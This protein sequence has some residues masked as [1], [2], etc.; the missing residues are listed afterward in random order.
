MQKNYLIGIGGTGA[1]V[2]ES[3][4][5]MCAAGYGPD[6]LSLFMVDP[7]A[8]NGNLA[9][10]SQL[11]KQY[12]KCRQK[13]QRSKNN[14]LF[15]TDLKAPEKIVWDIFDKKKTRLSD[16]INYQNIQIKKRELA[17]FVSVLFSDEELDTPLDEGFRG[18]PAIGAVVMANPPEDEYPF[19]I[20]WDDIVNQP[21]NGVRVFIVGSVF[22]GTGAA[23]FPTLGSKNLIKFNKNKNVILNEL[24]NESRIL[25]GGAL[26]L[27]YFSFDEKSDGEQTMHVNANDFPIA[28]KAA[29][30]YYNEKDLGF[31][32]IYFIGD[33]LAQKVGKFS[34]GSKTQE[35]LPH[36]IEIVSGLAAFDFY[37]QPEIKE[38][39]TQKFFYASRNA[40]TVSW[41][42]LPI[43]SDENIIKK[44]IVDFKSLITNMTVFA[45]SYCTYGKELR[46]MLHTN[47]KDAWYKEYFSYKERNDKDR[48]KDIRIGDNKDFL[49]NMELFAKAFLT[50]ICAI[51]N[52][53]AR[54][55]LLDRSKITRETVQVDKPIEL[56]NHRTYISNI[57]NLLCESSQNLDFNKFITT[58]MNSVQIS[59][60]DIS[61]AAMTYSSLFINLFSEG[62]AAF[63][64]KN[65]NIH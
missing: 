4:I 1:R 37:A 23:G 38:A 47:I 13:L 2:I 9:R 60:A 11:I 24:K 49:D 3:V 30:E 21:L 6:E 51:N 16:Y 55:K 35:N 53:N 7:D 41:N 12:N 62:T 33:S 45:Y 28:T 58:G 36:Y 63:C 39:P 17:D 8:G 15:H 50:W 18:H 19:K 48:H 61:A 40:E 27:P 42:D 34:V 64:K 46:E 59:S 25:L 14:R 56:L 32:Q 22:G 31:D 20:L 43:S 54:V 52:D 57:G 26:I 65:Y 5:Y 10:T 29:L 44:R